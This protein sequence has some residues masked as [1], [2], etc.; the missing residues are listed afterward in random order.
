MPEEYNRRF[1][2]FRKLGLSSRASNRLA[3]KNF[4]TIEQVMRASDKMLLS[5]GNI[6]RVTLKEIRDFA[7]QLEIASKKKTAITDQIQFHCDEIVRLTKNLT[8]I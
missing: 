4:D 3:I 5:L 2:Y 6:G 1:E 8:S 7:P